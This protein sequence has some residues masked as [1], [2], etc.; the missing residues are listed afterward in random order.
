MQVI[1]RTFSEFLRQPK[2]VVADLADHDVVLRRRNAP[3]LYLSLAA[4][5]ISRAKTIE[6]LARLLSKISADSPEAMDDAIEAAFPWVEFLSPE[7]RRK[8]AEDL[9]RTILA[10]ASIESFEPVEQTLLEWQNTAEILSDPE[11]TALLTTPITDTHG[12]R[13][14]PPPAVD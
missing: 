11:L 1:E 4:R 13:V 14:L 7:E 5:D 9:T 10:C 8:F 6:C 3:D 12:G 2:E